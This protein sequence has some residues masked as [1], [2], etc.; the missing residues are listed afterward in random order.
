MKRKPLELTIILALLISMVAGR[1]FIKEGNT[2]ENT[3]IYGNTDAK[4]TIQSPE[5]KIYNE[6]NVTLAF[7]IE[8]DVPPPEYF[9]GR[10]LGL[11]LR[12]G[13]VLDYDTAKLVD[14]LDTSTYPQWGFPDD[15]P[16][17]LSAIGDCY[18]GN[19][20]LTGLSPGA[21]NISVWMRAEQYMISY[22]GLVW[23]VFSTVTFSIPPQITV[24]SPEVKTYNISNVPLDFMVDGTFSKIEYSLDGQ[25]NMTINGNTTL[26]WLPNGYHNVS[27]YATDEFGNTGASE[28]VYFTVEVPEPFPTT[29]IAVAVIIVAVVV[30][31]LL[32]YFKKREV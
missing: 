22:S 6:N 25:S 5:N 16:I 13:V 18:V 17:T 31:G 2:S 24:L 4:V 26:T 3:I 21:H 10:V 28:I 32:V 19:A 30:I 27:L 11:C 20:T 8:S 9:D 1:I 23:A 14:I 7:T 15:V 12:H 29:L